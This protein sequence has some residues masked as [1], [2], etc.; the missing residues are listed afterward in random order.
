[1]SEGWAITIFTGMVVLVGVY[2]SHRFSKIIMN[3]QRNISNS[4]KLVED[5]QKR[6]A[7]TETEKVDKEDCVRVHERSDETIRRIHQRLDEIGGWTKEI[8]GYLKG[9]SNGAVL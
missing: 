2:L 3:E 4:D 9:R 5:I 1:M 8:H 7:L 6:L